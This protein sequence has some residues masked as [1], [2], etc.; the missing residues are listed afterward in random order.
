[1]DSPR[2]HRSPKPRLQG[3]R[4]KVNND[5]RDEGRTVLARLHAL[6]PRHAP[7][8]SS[9]PPVEEVR[10]EREAPY[11][12]ALKVR[13]I[14]WNM[15]DT[16]PK[17]NLDALLGDVPPLNSPDGPNPSASN[18]ELGDSTHPYHIIV[19]A[20]QECPTGLLPMGMGAV[21]ME[22]SKDKEKT[23]LKKDKD[24]T[25]EPKVKLAKPR[26]SE[27]DEYQPLADTPSTPFQPSTPSL[28]GAS[29]PHTSGWSAA[30]ED[31]LCK[32]RRSDSNEAAIPASPMSEHRILPLP[33]SPAPSQS[34]PLPPP[35]LPV[36]RNLAPPSPRRMA[37]FLNGHA[38]AHSNGHGAWN[39]PGAAGPYV[40]VAKERLMGIYLAIY[41]HRETR[42]LV[43]A[44]TLSG[45]PSGV[46]KSSVTAGLI[47]GRL[48]NKGGVGISMNVAGRSFL[49]VN[50]HLAAH[51]G[52]QAM[53]IENMEKI[54]AELRVDNFGEALHLRKPTPE[55][56][57]AQE[58]D[59][60]RN[61]MRSN[62]LFHGF[63]EPVIDFPPTFKYD[64]PKSRHHSRKEKD[65]KEKD[66]GVRASIRA[67]RRST[68]RKDKDK[69]KV[70]KSPNGGLKALRPLA[71]QCESGASSSDLE[72]P[73]HDPEED[74]DADSFT[75]SHPHSHSQSQPNL[76]FSR[77]PRPPSTRSQPTLPDSSADG[78]SAS[79]ENESFVQQNT[80]ANAQAPAG[81]ARMLSKGAKKGWRVLVVKSSADKEKRRSDLGGGGGAE[82]KRGVSSGPEVVLTGSGSGMNQLAG[83][84]EK[85][86]SQP[87]LVIDTTRD[88]APNGRTSVEGGLLSPGVGGSG[89]LSPGAGGVASPVTGGLLSPSTPALPI[90]GGLAPPPMIRANSS[91]GSSVGVEGAGEVEAHS[92]KG[93][94]D[95]SSKQRVPSWCDRIVYK[96]TVLPPQPPP[97][98]P[99]PHFP[100]PLTD[101]D[102]RF[103]LVGNILTGMRRRGSRGRKDS[104]PI[105]RVRESGSAKA[106]EALLAETRASPFLKQPGVEGH[107]AVPGGSGVGSSRSGMG[108]R[109]GSSGSAGKRRPGSAGTTGGEH[110][111][112]MQ[113]PRTNPFARLLHP[114]THGQ[115][116]T[117]GP[118]LIHTLSMEPEPQLPAGLNLASRPR[119]VSTSEG[120]D[121][122]PPAPP[123]KDEPRWWFF[124]Q[125]QRECAA[126]PEP[127]PEPEPVE[128][129]RKRGDIVCISYGTLDDKAMQ[130]LG[131]RSDHRP[132]LGKVTSLV[133]SIPTLLSISPTS[134]SIVF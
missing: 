36:T 1:M 58:F 10:E 21:K 89:M 114:H 103:G 86:K 11:E 118:G 24:P 57:R 61:N 70:P 67:A 107:D 37:T 119:S 72:D 22:R 59:E 51:E 41:V 75:S 49:F 85:A 108:P 46:S 71:E 117:Q 40:L 13:I 83:N 34:P 91:G 124:R 95:T 60:L 127:E 128:E 126:P 29:L 39:D 102:S 69:D 25:E 113:W 52:R 18:F 115:G 14:S 116:Q 74:S 56:L 78:E 31:W 38:H 66:R 96:S 77:K 35:P 64:V 30:L 54:Q 98:L 121:E 26:R 65:G 33:P 42:P 19:V 32:G 84:A 80:H 92:V 50:A 131:G 63:E 73:E 111:A 76:N 48:G 109:P 28:A 94:Y 110:P 88:C 68:R 2:K 87:N 43:R 97:S 130:R 99:L 5:S 6:F 62:K 81:L 82:R 120:V 122:T 47:G 105:P 44:G 125:R 79:D 27:E 100:P 134:I 90:A 3:V 133:L 16:L 7:S 9:P 55:Y 45:G 129:E 15:N 17:G 106:R 53:R 4:E 23:K 112:S 104:F 93:V 123:P 132:V 101:E 20:G 8:V 12:H